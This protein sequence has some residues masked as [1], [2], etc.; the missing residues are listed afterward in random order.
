MKIMAIDAS[1]SG[2]ATPDRAVEVADEETFDRLLAAED[3]LLVDFY[4]DWCVL[5]RRMTPRVDEAVDE[6][7]ATV[8]AV[9][10][11]V[12]PQ[13]ADRYGVRSIP[14]FLAFETGEVRE[15]LVGMQE[16]NALVTALE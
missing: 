16:L 12:L 15:R 14:T 5:C 9:D 4:A 7:D 3:R 2:D 10:V 1:R 6:V 13:V 8:A 11:E